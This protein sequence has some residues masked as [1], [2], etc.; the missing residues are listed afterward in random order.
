M[1]GNKFGQLAR[2]SR[3]E[4][5]RRRLQTLSYIGLALLAAATVFVVVVA[6]RR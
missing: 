3:R 1:M 2:E 5:R 6:L 4:Q